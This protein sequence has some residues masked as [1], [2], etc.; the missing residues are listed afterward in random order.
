VTRLAPVLFGHETNIWVADAKT[1][2]LGPVVE[3]DLLSFFF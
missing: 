2:A 1:G 3:G